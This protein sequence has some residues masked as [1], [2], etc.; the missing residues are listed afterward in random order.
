MSF[1]NRL[2]QARKNNFMTPEELAERLGV[3][4]RTISKWESS[5]ALP[6]IETALNL[7]VILR[8][9]LDWLWNDELFRAEKELIGIVK[10]GIRSF[11]EYFGGLR[12]GETYLIGAR[13]AMGRTCLALNITNNLVCDQSCKVLYFSLDITLEDTI[14]RI[15]KIRTGIDVRRIG[16]KIED[17]ERTAEEIERICETNLVIDGTPGITLDQLYRKCISE[18]NLDLVVIDQFEDLDYLSYPDAANVLQRIARECSC[19]VLGLHTIYEDLIQKNGTDGIEFKNA[20]DAFEE[21]G[22]NPWVFDNAY[23]LHRPFYYDRAAAPDAYL[24]IAKD[25]AEETGTCV[26]GYHAE[27]YRLE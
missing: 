12:R 13:T 8:V 17:R 19:P 24:H 20:R 7:A 5:E 9:S 18:K 27:E 2:Q 21:G 10:T 3:S 16:E 6:D 1:G 11:D 15:L 22:I 14:S 26:M 4:P 23:L 25:S